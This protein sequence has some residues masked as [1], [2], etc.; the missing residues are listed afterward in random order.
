MKITTT[1][2]FLILFTNLQASEPE[3]LVK[4]RQT[5]HDQLKK[6]IK[7]IDLNYMNALKNMRLKLTQAGDLHGAL[8]VDAEIKNVQKELNRRT[9]FERNT[10]LDSK[11][12]L[13]GEYQYQFDGRALGTWKIFEDGSIEMGDVDGRWYIKDENLY[14][15]TNDG[16]VHWVFPVTLNKLSASAVSTT[17]KRCTITK[18]K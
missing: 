7:P 13:V 8:A 2:F 6:V 4:M 15:Y 3:E 16:S 10:R 9:A 17:S 12:N 5:W 14:A 11:I 1:L 18:I